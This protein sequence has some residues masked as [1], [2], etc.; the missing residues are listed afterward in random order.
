MGRASTLGS[1]NSL[2]ISL[3]NDSAVF[4]KANLLIED[5]LIVVRNEAKGGFVALLNA[6]AA[7]DFD[8]V[9]TASVT[10]IATI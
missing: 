1:T 10:C 3:L 7:C 9:W 2:S 8:F 6:N 5:K 4:L